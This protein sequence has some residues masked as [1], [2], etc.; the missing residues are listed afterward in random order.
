MPK[1]Q[2]LHRGI[3]AA[4]IGGLTAALVFTMPGAIPAAHADP[5]D[6]A[7][8][9]LV[10]LEEQHSQI[11]SQYTA[12]QQK[13]TEAEGK[14][15]TATTDLGKQEKLVSGMRTRAVQ[16]ALYQFQTRGTDVN[17]QLFTS[18]NPDAFLSKISTT[19][20]F[21]S[22]INGSLQSYQ[23]EVGN[24]ESL[25]RTISSE[26]ETVRTEK[27]RLGK[28]SKQADEKIEQQKA[29]ISRLTAEQRAA[30]LERER[31]QNEAA[32]TAANGGENPVPAP[33]N[34]GQSTTSQRSTSQSD[35]NR[36]TSTTSRS[37]KVST[38]TVSGP[39]SE[40]A[41]GALRYALAQ[42]GK[43]YRMGAAGPSAFDCSGLTMASYASVGISIP[44]TSQAQFR[45][46]RP[47][48]RGDLQP[49]DL[50]FFYS[51]IS[52]V[53]IYMGNGIMVDARNSRVGVVYTNINEPWWPYAGA[54]RIA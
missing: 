5:I 9:E 35:S 30:L 44:R 10:R 52:H 39:A 11:E 1:L 48:S 28:L 21:E 23:A 4:A 14:L 40:R 27:E 47:V 29:V 45:V 53:G 32:A 7:K 25:K 31:R 49:G 16:V 54:R 37:R 42:L 51:G 34:T 2:K 17:A 36:S 43:R 15:K 26:T 41:K 24:L 20:Q 38:P 13:V 22:N 18:S 12:A 33:S 19:Q 46:G 50:V 3:A 8:A 6:D